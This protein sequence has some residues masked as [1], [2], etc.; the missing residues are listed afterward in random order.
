[1]LKQSLGENSALATSGI[2]KSIDQAIYYWIVDIKDFGDH[3]KEFKSS[4]LKSNEEFDYLSQP[5]T[6]IEVRDSEWVNTPP[7]NLNPL[8]VE[9]LYNPLAHSLRKKVVFYNK[10]FG[11][12]IYGE[13][14]VT[15]KYGANVAQTSRTSDYKQDDELWGQEA[16]K[17][18]LYVEDAKF[19][20][21]ADM[22]AIAIVARI[23]AD[24]GNFIGVIKA[25]VNIKVFTRII[26]EADYSR[27]VGGGKIGLL[28]SNGR[29]IYTA[30][31]SSLFEV[32]S[33]YDFFKEEIK[34][35]KQG[36]VSFSSLHFSKE[37]NFSEEHIITFSNSQGFEQFEGLGWSIIIKQDINRI[38]APVATLRNKIMTFSFL[39]IQRLRCTFRHSKLGCLV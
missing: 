36:F 31:N 21:S 35:D 19:D 29:V 14:F 3:E 10:T 27:M 34:N 20:E 23:D 37:G 7:E 32:E 24:E 38:L 1:M 6:E 22:Y 11:Y 25:V 28:S 8:M 17:T 16:K 12:P 30:N 15:N 13:I 18:G 39:M 5:F 26:D 2:M 33:D 4:L 9:L